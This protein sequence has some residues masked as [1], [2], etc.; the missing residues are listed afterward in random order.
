M[1]KQCS[2]SVH[3]RLLDS[4]GYR[5]TR[6]PRMEITY[7]AYLCGEYEAKEEPKPT[8]K[9]TPPRK[10]TSRASAAVTSLAKL[11]SQH[12]T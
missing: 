12:G 1:E 9:K 4:F 2:T 8:P 11:S 3:Y 5:C 10:S 7:L 6:Y